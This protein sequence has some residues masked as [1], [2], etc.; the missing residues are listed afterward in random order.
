MTKDFKTYKLPPRA[1]KRTTTNGPAAT[2]NNRLA[3]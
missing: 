3:S 1:D 2:T